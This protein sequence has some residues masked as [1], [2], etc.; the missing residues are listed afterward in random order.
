MPRPPSD[1]SGRSDT[2]AR[3]GHRLVAGLL[4]WVVGAI[5]P[6]AC[7]A[8]ATPVEARV[9]WF[10]GA[11]ALIAGDDSLGIEPG[12]GVEFV[13]RGRVIARGEVA[14]VVDRG[15]ALATISSGSL[16][17]VRLD[18][19]RVWVVRPVPRLASLRIGY[20]SRARPNPFRSDDTLGVHPPVEAGY[21]AEALSERGMRWVGTTGTDTAWPESLIVRR[22]DDAADQEFALERDEIDVAVFWPGEPSRS[23]RDD[24]RRWTLTLVR[25]YPVVYRPDLRRALGAIGLER[26]LGPAVPSTGEATR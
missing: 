14:K 13:R 8:A 2:P 3:H 17:G 1:P 10:S 20:P 7:P 9:V 12:D 23:L 18:R 16:R 26:L 24:D 21:R 4:V 25:E 15:I 6:S 22:F 19:V 5:A 11:R